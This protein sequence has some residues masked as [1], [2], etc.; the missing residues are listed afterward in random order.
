M[1]L[2][3]L[4]PR[5]KAS[6]GCVF[7]RNLFF[8]K[9]FKIQFWGGGGLQ[10]YADP[11]PA[12]IEF[13]MLRFQGRL[14]TLIIEGAIMQS[15]DTFTGQILE[16]LKH[17]SVIFAKR[18]AV[19]FRL[20]TNPVEYYAPLE[21]A[22]AVVRTILI[23]IDAAFPPT[24]WQRLFS[25]YHLPNP[26]GRSGKTLDGK[27]TYQP[28]Q[29]EI[30]IRKFMSLFTGVGLRDPRGTVD[31]MM[32]IEPAAVVAME[33]GFTLRQAWG[34]RECNVPRKAEGAEGC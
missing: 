9:I 4:P 29:K 6:G 10:D 1:G 30:F 20:P 17:P 26:L 3:T 13:W 25:A 5:G 11:D 32:S 12:D 2:G 23:A 27:T 21:R 8:S 7:S 15:V 33:Q 34:A 16:F 31:E 18:Q 19:L 14:K 28:A 22:R 24:C